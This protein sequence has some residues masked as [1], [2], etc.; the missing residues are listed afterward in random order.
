MAKRT[1]YVLFTRREKNKALRFRDAKQERLY[2][3]LRAA[4]D[5]GVEIDSKNA[6]EFAVIECQSSRHLRRPRTYAVFVVV[7]ASSRMASVVAVRSRKYCRTRAV[8]TGLSL[9]YHVVS[10][11]GV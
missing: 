11:D 6:G 8:W 4:T 10:A 7:S 3:E 9:L 2:L 5:D 1:T